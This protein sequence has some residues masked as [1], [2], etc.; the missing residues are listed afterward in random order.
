MGTDQ[1]CARAAIETTNVS[2]LIEMDRNYLERINLRKKLIVEHTGD[3][4]AAVNVSK[5]AVDEFYTWLVGNYLPTRFPTMFCLQCNPDTQLTELFSHATGEYYSLTPKPH[6]KDS[7]AVLGGLVEDD[8]LFLLPAGDGDGYELKAFVTCFPNGFST[9]KKLNMKLRDI[10]TP[11]PSY[12]EKMQLSM[13]RWF[14]RLE[15]GTFVRRYNVRPPSCP[16]VNDL[17]S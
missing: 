17:K 11:V 16:E 3:V 12:K 13:D 2:E 8:L 14:Q 10:H 15:A 4:L 1:S 7:L 9:R 6:P 5:P